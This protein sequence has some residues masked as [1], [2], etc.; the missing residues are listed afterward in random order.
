VVIRKGNFAAVG[1]FLW[2][3]GALLFAQPC[4]IP[5]RLLA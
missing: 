3:D 1:N 4:T 5:S 2:I